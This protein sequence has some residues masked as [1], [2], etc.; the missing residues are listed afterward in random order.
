MSSC[1]HDSIPPGESAQLE[2]CRRAHQ[3]VQTAFTNAPLAKREKTAK[4]NSARR[5]AVGEHSEEVPAAFLQARGREKGSWAWPPIAGACRA[6]GPTTSTYAHQKGHAHFP[7]IDHTVCPFNERAG[8]G[9]CFVTCRTHPCDTPAPFSRPSAL[10]LHCALL[11]H[12]LSLS[13]I[14]FGQG[15][16]SFWWCWLSFALAHSKA[17]GVREGGLAP[18]PPGPDAVD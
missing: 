3:H 5:R 12:C 4:Q 2:P 1:R 14:P 11:P 16:P 6:E 18:R 8:K 13:L 10:C 17:L 9:Q 15:A 7:L